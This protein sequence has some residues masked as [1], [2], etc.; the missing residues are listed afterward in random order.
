MT[1]TWQQLSGADLKAFQEEIY[2]L[3]RK[4]YMHIGGHPDFQSPNDVNENEAS[5]WKYVDTDSDGEPDAISAAKVTPFGKKSV[6][7]ATDGTPEAKRALVQAKISDLNSP[8]NYAEVSDRIAEILL[9]AGVPIVDN[10][11]EVK[12]VL[13][14]KQIQWLS[15]GWYVRKI[16]GTDHKK[17]MVGIPNI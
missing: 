10:E 15:G 14:G 4:S 12:K 5:F 1:G 11:E 7:G 8:G 13:P 16:G 3:I 9:Q 2:E 6:V 17:I